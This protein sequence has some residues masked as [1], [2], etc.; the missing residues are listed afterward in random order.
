MTK[1]YKEL[2]DSLKE[3]WIEVILNDPSTSKVQKL[4]L[5]EENTLFDY[6]DTLT[7]VA[8]DWEQELYNLIE[9]S[10]PP[11]YNWNKHVIITDDL[12]NGIDGN[13][14]ERYSFLDVI[15]RF[16]YNEFNKGENFLHTVVIARGKRYKDF[17]IKKTLNEII[18]KIFDYAV[19]NRVIGF[20]IDW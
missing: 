4:K 1:N 8:Q 10:G 20:E 18:D 5:L 17:V 13:R 16:K 9:N 19:E 7:G 14:H 12:I 3:E 6:E 2:I 11:P 15:Q